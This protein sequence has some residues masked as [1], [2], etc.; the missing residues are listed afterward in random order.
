M[1]NLQDDH[2]DR[3]SS[4]RLD[5]GVHVDL[6]QQQL[7]RLMTVQKSQR[8]TVSKHVRH[9]LKCVS[10][11]CILGAEATLKRFW[12]TVGID[13]KGNDFTVTLDSRPLK[14]PSGN[15]LLLP[16]DK[17]VLA[18]LVAHEWDTQETLLK[19]HA[20]PMVFH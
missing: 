3:T 13:K 16:E 4:G 11:Y 5:L 7:R 10:T 8:Q 17:G 1:S 18:T 19:P 12:K 15:T 2:L 9:Q 6:Q 20:L 14:T